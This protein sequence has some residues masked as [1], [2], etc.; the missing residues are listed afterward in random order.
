L[1]GDEVVVAVLLLFIL[2]DIG[3]SLLVLTALW[4]NEKEGAKSGLFWH[5]LLHDF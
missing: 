3:L 5:A 2:R 4:L 1:E